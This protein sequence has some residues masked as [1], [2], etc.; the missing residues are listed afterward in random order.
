MAA[1]M[2]GGKFDHPDRLFASLSRTYRLVS[3]MDVKE[4]LPQFFALPEMFVNIHAF[5]FGLTQSKERVDRITLPIWANGDPRWFVRAMRK[6]IESDYVS[7]NLHLWIELI[8]GHKQ[9][10]IYTI[11]IL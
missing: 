11:Y 9:L 10:V 2:Q 5:D 8:F 1:I 4:M 3:T 7:Q 6:A